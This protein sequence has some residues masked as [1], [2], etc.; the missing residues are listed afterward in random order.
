[1]DIFFGEEEQQQVPV[2]P[3]TIKVLEEIGFGRK[4][5][6]DIPKP[7]SKNG[8]LLLVRIG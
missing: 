7:S 8:G 5:L 4:L 6:R 3:F 1:L 2:R